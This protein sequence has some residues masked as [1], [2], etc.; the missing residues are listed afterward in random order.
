MKSHGRGNVSATSQ[1]ISERSSGNNGDANGAVGVWSGISISSI[2]EKRAKKA[3]TNCWEKF[4][5]AKKMKLCWKTFFG[6]LNKL[7]KIIMDIPK[8][9]WCYSIPMSQ[10]NEMIFLVFVFVFVFFSI[11]RIEMKNKMIWTACLPFTI[12]Q[13]I[14]AFFSFSIFHFFDLK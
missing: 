2:G 4:R 14:E 10:N 12:V 11:K 6:R 13:K 3:N 1:S 9:L 8:K 5:Q 7:W